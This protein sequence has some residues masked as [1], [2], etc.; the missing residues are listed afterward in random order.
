MLQV[1]T[2][3]ANSRRGLILLAGILIALPNALPENVIAPDAGLAAEPTRS[4][5]ASIC[6]A[7]PT[8]CSK[9]NSTQVQKDKLETL[10]GDIRARPAQGA[11]RLQRS[12]ARRGDTVSVRHPR[13]GALRR[14]QDD[15][16]D[17][18]PPMGG[19]VLAVGAHA[20]D[21]TE[22]GNGTLVAEDDRCLQDRRPRPRSSASPSKWCA[23]ASTQWARASR[24]SSGRATTAFWCRCRALQDPERLK[25]ILG[26]TAKMT[27]QLVDEARRHRSRRRKGIVPDRRR[28]LLYRS[29]GPKGA[30]RSPIVVEKRVMVAGD[31]LTRRAG[32]IRPADR[33]AGRQFPLRQRRRARVR[34]RDQGESSD[35]RFAIVLDNKVISAPVI[36]EPILGGSGEISGNFHHRRRANDLAVLLRAGALA[37]AAQGHRG[38]HGRRRAR[39]GLDQGRQDIRPSAGWSWSRCS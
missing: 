5:S 21:I 19:G 23:G 13:S 24:P 39:R 1:S 16:K 7:A 11:Y 31:R 27:F 4:A 8:C 9:S 34:Q 30:S 20:Y 29:N 10:V 35:R 28:S 22:P 17:L 38:A 15:L 6:R 25:S 2:L 32:R 37:R 3:V 33:R 26:K 36:R 18:N 14:R 12:A